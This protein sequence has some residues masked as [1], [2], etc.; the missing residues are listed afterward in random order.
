VNN[1]TIHQYPLAIRLLTFI[2]IIKK[3]SNKVIYGF[4]S[5]EL[6]FAATLNI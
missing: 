5:E 4:S 2:N 3:M 1:S 6:I